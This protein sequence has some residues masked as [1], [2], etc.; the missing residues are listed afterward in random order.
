[1]PLESVWKRLLVYFYSFS[2]HNCC[3]CDKLHH[4]NIRDWLLTPRWMFFWW[5]WARRVGF[6]L[7]IAGVS[8]SVNM[9]PWLASQIVQL[10]LLL[11]L[12][13]IEFDN[14]EFC[15]IRL[16]LFVHI[17]VLSSLLSVNTL[18]IVVLALCF[19]HSC[20][21]TGWPISFWDRGVLRTITAAWPSRGLQRRTSNWGLWELCY[22]LISSC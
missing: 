9:K 6:H 5:N 18:Y 3:S 8:H 22:V 13:C 4:V 12:S 19:A 2:Q 21:G 20:L 16:L 11:S 14:C 10:D 7:L 15:C 1:M 17:I